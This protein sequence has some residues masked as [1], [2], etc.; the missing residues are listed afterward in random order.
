MKGK[1]LSSF[2]LIWLV[3]TVLMV[4]GGALNLSQ[5]AW[6]QLPPTDGVLWTQ[7]D[8]GVYA[9]SL[10]RFYRALMEISRSRQHAIIPPPAAPA[11]SH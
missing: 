9:E 2:G 8:D 1:G 11:D 6:H 3:A 5:R 10:R 4:A 7:K